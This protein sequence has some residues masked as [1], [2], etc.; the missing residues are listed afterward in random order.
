MPSPIN[1]EIKTANMAFMVFLECLSNMVNSQK[2]NLL[3]LPLLASIL[4]SIVSELKVGPKVDA[5]FYSILS[6]ATSP[7]AKLRL[8]SENQYTY[9]KNI[10]TI[11]K[12]NRDQK[13][14]ISRLLTENEYLKQAITDKKVLDNLKNTF[15]KAVPV[16]I[17]GS[18]GKFVVSSSLPLTDV[19]PGQPLVSGN[20][21]LGTVLEVKGPAVTIIPLESEKSPSFPLRTASGQKGFYKY[22]N[23]H[24]QITDI[25]SQNP[26]VLGDF[27]FTEP[28]ELF[29]GNLIIGKI[30]RLLTIN[31]EPL[32]K[33]EIVLY[34]TLD[35]NPDNLAIVTLP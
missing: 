2:I 7:I 19:K 14:Q 32:Q 6:P 34:D 9:V 15:K 16:R 20:V 28:G 12:Q 17:S 18:T 22:T 27:V 4:L 11:E 31:Q 29:P 25:P 30:A 26:I 8:F 5:L 1:T 33:A 3:L 23:N 24:P 35:N 21:L 13:N 10:S